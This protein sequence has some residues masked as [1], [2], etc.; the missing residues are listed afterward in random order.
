M[1]AVFIDFPVPEE[2]KAQVAY[3]A[4]FI[5]PA[6]RAVAHA[7]ARWTF[8]LA[9]PVSE[10]VLSKGLAAL[11]KR[12]ASATA[13]RPEPIFR[14]EPSARDAGE[15][16]VGALAA[17]GA[18]RAIHPGLFVFRA[19]VATIIRFL[20]HAILARIARPFG[21]VEEAYPN[22]IPLADLGATNHFASFPEHLHFL[23]HLT[24]DLDVLDGFAASA[25]AQGAAVRPETRQ[26]SPVQLVHNPSTCY[27]C[28]AARRGTTIAGDV[29][30]TAIA[31]CHRYE[32]ANH[33]DLGRLLEFS[34]REV[35]F[36][37][38]PDYVRACREKTLAL[39][40]ALAEDWRLAGELLPSNDP[41]FTSDFSAK[42]GQQLRL[43]MKFEYRASLPGRS[44]KLAIMSSNLHGPTFSKTFAMRRDGG[45]LHTGCLGFGLERLALA[46]IAQH[47]HE[48]EA[49]P[50]GLRRD[51]ADWRRAD[52]LGA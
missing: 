31:K 47:G 16:R 18:I 5:H 43:A 12:F 20:D 2:S 45:P 41:F 48:P 29:A 40:T 32:A 23:T 34:L 46:L 7:G 36:L 15:D 6:V 1:V 28:Y 11:A 39:V 38:S 9:E 30:V 24:Q 13:F 50:E 35:I 21:A 37:G 26:L 49:W 52:P 33:A 42:A 10:A 44:K 4:A 51:F 3:A 8:D 19:P 17:A 14:L 22:C 25:S 27:H